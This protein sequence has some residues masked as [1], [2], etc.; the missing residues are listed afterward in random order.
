MP[1]V[2]DQ[3]YSNGVCHRENC[4]FSHDVHT[5]QTCR[6]VFETDALFQT[7]LTT[8]FHKQKALQEQKR[9]AGLNLPVLCTVCSV[10][11]CT[12]AQ[13]QP[14]S[15][16]KRHMRL[17]REQ[18][19]QSDPGP[20]ELDIPR[21]C[22]RCETCST[23]VLTRDWAQHIRG[24]RHTKA[25]T[26]I[27]LQGAI[28][29]SEKDKNGIVISPDDLDFGFLDA[30]QSRKSGWSKVVSVENTNVTAVQLVEARLSSQ[31]TTRQSP[32]E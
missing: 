29:E 21:N 15:R 8:A 1:E 4:P 22:T 32:T 13:Y 24:Q 10:D 12:A 31:M 20:E 19:L 3:I 25:S 30:P 2:C 9:R 7:H 27:T 26:F 23:N 11:L 28:D 17:M 5:C 6:Q 14:H 16:G 18:G